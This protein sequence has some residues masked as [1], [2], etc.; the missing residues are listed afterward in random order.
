YLFGHIKQNILGMSLRVNL[1]LTPNLTIQYWGQPFIATGVYDRIKMVTNPLADQ[2]TDRFHLCDQGQLT[3]Y[4]DDGYCSIDEDR[5][6]SVDYYV[7]YPDFNIKEF[8]SNFVIRWEYRPGSILY[9][10][11]SQGRSGYDSYGDFAFK[12]DLK[13]MFD[14]YPHNIFLV[15]LSYRFGL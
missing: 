2:Y 5:D 1:T 14:V 10:V 13:S 12:R 15:K 3:C 11:W 9:L 6:G 8:K 7:G 4:S